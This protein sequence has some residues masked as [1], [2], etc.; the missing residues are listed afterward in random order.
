MFSPGEADLMFCP[1]CRARI[2]GLESQFGRYEEQERRLSA[3]HWMKPENRVLWDW[4]IIDECGRST[5]ASDL[6]GRYRR[7]TYPRP[8]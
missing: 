7:D 8:A 5:W 4:E 2:L 1:G 3:A 6:A